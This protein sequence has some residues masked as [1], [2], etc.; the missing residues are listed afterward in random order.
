MRTGLLIGWLAGVL[1]LFA[2]EQVKLE[3]GIAQKPEQ[4]WVR[5]S[6][7]MQLETLKMYIS[8]I[9]FHRAGQI[10]YE[11]DSIFL[12][13]FLERPER[14]VTIPSGLAYD[15]ISFL[16]GIDS[17]V[18]VSGVFGGDL[19]PTSGMYWTWQSG[20]IHFKL[21]MHSIQKTNAEKW[22]LH[23]GGY[24]ADKACYGSLGFHTDQRHIRAVLDISAFATQECKENEKQ[25]MSPGLAAVSLM[26]RLT[27]Y[28]FLG[29]EI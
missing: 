21:E 24:A 10:Q 13:D 9:D 22:S 26:Q 15:S 17:T 12:I 28:F 3:F 14:I 27:R 6:D 25:I 8:H 7:T 2:Q 23:L 4:V 16:I 1:P 11:S 20:Y 5:D 19:D 29:N 18:S